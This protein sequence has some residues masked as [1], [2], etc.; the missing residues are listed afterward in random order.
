MKL[1][2][3]TRAYQIEQI[4]MAGVGQERTFQAGENIQSTNNTTLHVSTG[5]MYYIHLYPFSTS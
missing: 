2:I 5:V 4:L 1:N 3:Q